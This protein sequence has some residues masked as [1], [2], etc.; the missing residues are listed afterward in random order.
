[1]LFGEIMKAT[2]QPLNFIDLFSGAGGLSCGLEMAG[3]KCLLGV[4]F[5][6][7]A[8]KTFKKNHPK[9]ETFCGDINKLKSD[10]IAKL[11]N[12]QK[13]HLVAGG[14]PC[15]G[16]STVGKGNPN[17]MR[18]KLFK[19]FIRVVKDFNPEFV[20]MENVTGLMAKKNEKSLQSIIK[21][22]NKLGYN[23][24]VNI[25]SSQNYGVAEKRRR[26]IFICSRINN[27]ISFPEITHFDHPT[28]KRHKYTNTVADA[29]SDLSTK[30]GLIHNHDIQLALIKNPI[31]LKRIKRIPE[32][33]G[34]RYERDEKAYLTKS[35]KL[36]I[37]WEKTPENRLR[38]TKYQRL[39]SSRPSPTIMTHRHNYYH[40]RENRFLTQR[41]AASIQSFPN[42]FVFFGSVTSQ[43]RQIG[44]AV[45]PLLGKSIGRA[46]NLMYNSSNKNVK[47]DSISKF[48]SEI[49]QKRGRA[50]KYIEKSL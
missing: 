33:K 15:Q 37:D 12:H 18:N 28:L 25:L 42:S 44:N 5:D 20:V 21:L 22:F 46:I 8:I 9:S 19:Q 13:V 47:I 3:L 7:D 50:F 2:K 40:P 26:T 27:K 16:F 6:R 23:I 49:I 11:T 41:E 34:I 38:Q 45:P 31:D 10:E 24:D 35:L 29:L 48:K 36:D 39:D 17:D 4:D 43:W 14:P 32:G 30:N 1:M